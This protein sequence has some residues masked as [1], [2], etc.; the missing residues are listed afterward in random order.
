MLRI[1]CSDGHYVDKQRR[2]VTRRVIS[3]CL[4]RAIHVGIRVAVNG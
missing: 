2:Y 1:A 3:C 4:S